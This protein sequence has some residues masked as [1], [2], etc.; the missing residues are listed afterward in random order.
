MNFT[1]YI[2]HSISDKDPFEQRYFEPQYDMRDFVG[3]TVQVTKIEKNFPWEPWYD[4][5]TYT[6][7]E[8]DVVRAYED[9][10]DIPV[11]VDEVQGDGVP[12][13]PGDVIWEKPVRT[14]EKISYNTN[15]GFSATI[16]IPLDGGLQERCKAAADTQIG[17]Q[18]QIHANKRLDFEIA[19]LK[20]CG[21]LMKAGIMFRPGT[22]YAAICADVIVMNK[23]AI[24]PH[25]QYS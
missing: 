5:R 19:R 18:Q 14:G 6:N 24:A 12:D 3:R 21:E 11:I 25:A 23:N 20:N 13:N 10:A 9:G 1:P 8:G 15:I 22:K 16:S 17:L 2:T 7:S 4:D